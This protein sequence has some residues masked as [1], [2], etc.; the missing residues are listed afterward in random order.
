MWF[1]DVYTA[2]AAARKHPDASPAA[3]HVPDRAAPTVIL[4]AEQD[5][6][7]DEGELYSMR[8]VQPGVPLEQKRFGGQIHGFAGL[9]DELPG[10]ADAVDF[11]V[12]ALGRDPVVLGG[13][14]TDVDAARSHPR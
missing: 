3:G 1:S 9:V 10:S 12:A 5:V 4:T 6:V 11:I 13:F 7:R 14:A 2:D 8:L